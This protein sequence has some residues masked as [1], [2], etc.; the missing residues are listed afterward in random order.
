MSSD[1]RLGTAVTHR[2]YVPHAHAHYGGGLVD[3]AYLLGLFGDAATELCTITDGDEGL[4]AS[5]DDVQFL[6][7]VQGG[8]VVEVAATLTRTGR[9]S[10]R[11]T[12]EAR[13]TSRARPDVGLSAAAV[14]D[15]P[16][17]A[18]TASG[19][20]VVP[21][22]TPAVSAASPSRLNG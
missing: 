11:M 1:P 12:F 21:S 8:D 18:V 2:R 16:I 4:F 7:P 17:V 19:T 9:R 6:A 5:Y 3:G 15:P 14:L 10:R 13:V 22:G 20:V